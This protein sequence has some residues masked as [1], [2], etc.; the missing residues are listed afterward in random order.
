MHVEQLMENGGIRYLDTHEMPVFPEF[1]KAL[2]ILQ[3][4]SG[5]IDSLLVKKQTKYT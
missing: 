3:E 2:N 5:E 4:I 1:K